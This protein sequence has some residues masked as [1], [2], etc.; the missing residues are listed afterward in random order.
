MLAVSGPPIVFG[1]NERRFRVPKPVAWSPICVNREPD[2]LVGAGHVGQR[3]RSQLP[4]VGGRGRDLEPRAPWAAG[5]P[6][7]C[8]V[9]ATAVGESRV[10]RSSELLKLPDREKSKCSF[11]AAANSTST[12]RL[13]AFGTLKMT[14]DEHEPAVTVACRSSMSM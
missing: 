1:A 12:P 9:T 2:V 3:A 8:P 11:G 4:L 13:R 14:R 6:P 5:P 7:G 10:E